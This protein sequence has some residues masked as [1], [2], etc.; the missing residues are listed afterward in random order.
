M[1]KVYL[2][3]V[4]AD[5]FYQYRHETKGPRI[6]ALGQGLRY[7]D[8]AEIHLLSNRDVDETEELV[9]W[10][11]KETKLKVKPNIEYH[12][13]IGVT[14]YGAL[15]KIVETK[16][17]EL[18]E[19]H[20]DL[21]LVLHTSTGTRQMGAVM[22]LVGKEYGAR[23]INSWKSGNTY[24]C[25]EAEIPLDITSVLRS[26]IARSQENLAEIIG[27]SPPMM[28]AK[29]LAA[30]FALADVPILILGETGTGKELFAKAIN[31]QARAP[32]RDPEKYIPVN[33]S[34][35]TE[36][37]IAHSELFGH[38]QGSFTGA[39]QKKCGIFERMDG[40][41]VFLDEFGELPLDT[42]KN[43]L[44]VAVDYG[45]QEI[46][47]LGAD[48]PTKVNVRIIAATNR[49][50]GFDA[51]EDRFRS[52][53]YHRIAIGVIKLPPLR[54]RAGD[55]QL[56]VQYEMEKIRK[57][58]GRGRLTVS[59]SA[60]EYITSYSWPGNVRELK[61]VLLRACI[62][63]DGEQLTDMDIRESIQLGQPG[64]EEETETRENAVS[65]RSTNEIFAEEDRML[66]KLG[67]N[68]DLRDE[69]RNIEQRY[70]QLALRK[71]NQH[72]GKAAAELGL[73]SYQDVSKRL[74]KTEAINA[75][76]RENA[77]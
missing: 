37:T 71:T 30:K 48:N 40:G 3:W 34:A 54:E 58:L 41:T 18:F 12:K 27:E 51:T 20:R 67:P 57:S 15:Y 26:S 49:E 11:G 47:P 69:L 28:R 16:V 13:S 55:I 74:K 56:L 50:L 24:H 61:N 76:G 33:C 39:H 45:K 31:A 1:T 5:D 75:R 14:D 32:G 4:G 46:L 65:N 21:D 70:I 43:L 62:L 8:Y 25:V 63:C 53:L 23:C 72:R 73:K 6:A 60:M 35:F 59:D 7:D 66:S 68:F 22:V 19:K 38:T 17:R 44:R 64:T 2:S 52:D 29:H 9:D 36:P 42:Q 77:R 10:L